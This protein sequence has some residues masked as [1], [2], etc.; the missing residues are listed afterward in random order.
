MNNVFDS[1][2]DDYGEENIL[3]AAEQ[4]LTKKLNQKVPSGYVKVV[5][6]EQV[7]DVL[8]LIDNS[9][10]DVTEAG[11]I[12]QE[13]YGER[14]VLIRQITQ[15]ETAVKLVEAEAI[16]TLGGETAIIEGKTARVKTGAEQDMYRRYMS[17]EERT[18]L[19][20]LQGDLKALEMD[21]Y[22]AKDRWDEAKLTAELI[23]SRANVQ[24]N[25]LGFLS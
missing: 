25:L 5:Q 13:A 10:K 15:L 20:E 12:V 4:L 14:S 9:I 11:K 21:S 1:L 17:R 16:M 18:K 22:K 24:A 3:K 6:P 8:D 2:I 23:K 19:A 7:E